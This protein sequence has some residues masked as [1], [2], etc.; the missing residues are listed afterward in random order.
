[1]EHFST[2]NF[3]TNSQFGFRK[4]AST[5]NATYKLTNDIVMALTNK[6]KSRGIFFDLEKAFDCVNHDILLAKA[7]YYGVNGVMYSLIK[8]YL[9]NRY[10][11]V[12]FNNKL[13]SWGE[14][15]IGVPQGSILG[16]LLFL[17]YVN[18]LPSFI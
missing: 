5:I 18:D 6:K 14:M 11:R 1:M 3:L 17:I 15:N 4:N 9:E 8:S 10:Q 12:K 7:K 2:N 13:S 16:P